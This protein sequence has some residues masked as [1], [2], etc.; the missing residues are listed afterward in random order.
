MLGIARRTREINTG[1]Q[2][3]ALDVA[4]PGAASVINC[5]CARSSRKAFS[6]FSNTTAVTLFL[7]ES[8][9]DP[10]DSSERTGFHFSTKRS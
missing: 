8:L 10:A 2:L 3:D 7:C 4:F 9:I 1:S 5:D 6:V